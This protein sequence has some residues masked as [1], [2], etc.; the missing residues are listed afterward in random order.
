MSRFEHLV[1]IPMLLCLLASSSAAADEPLRWKWVAGQEF[2]VHMTQQTEADTS[3]TGKSVKLRVDV[4]LDWNWSVERVIGDPP[5]GI[6]R[7]TINRIR[8]SISDGQNATKSY[9]SEAKRNPVDLSGAFDRYKDLTLTMQMQPD[10]SVVS[11]VLADAAREAL[12][13]GA[14]G[15]GA[16]SDIDFNQMLRQSLLVFPMEPVPV[17]GSWK[18]SLESTIPTGRLKLQTT[19]VHAGEVNEAGLPLLKFTHSSEL[20][21]DAAAANSELS[22]SEHEQT[23]TILF[24]ATAGRM[25][26]SKTQ[27]RLKSQARKRET[28]IDTTMRSTIEMRISPR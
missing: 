22:I 17:G 23:G 5:S 7:Q 25:V 12:G 20:S 11:V 18:G 6:V 9:D 19:Y 21:R 16:E 3:Y 24:D 8:A 27:Q 1:A 26:S 2:D 15:K 14:L 13:K 28:L 10:G 4:T